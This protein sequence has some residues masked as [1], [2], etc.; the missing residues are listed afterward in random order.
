[1][2]QKDGLHAYCRTAERSTFEVNP[3]SM[4]TIEHNSKSRLCLNYAQS[5]AIVEKKN[6][7]GRHNLR[8]MEARYR[9]VAA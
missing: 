6:I 1:M 2:Y 4:S 7:H 9:E 5:R 3:K 8:L